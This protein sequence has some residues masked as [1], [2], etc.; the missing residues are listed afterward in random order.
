MYRVSHEWVIRIL[1]GVVYE[2]LKL[3]GAKGRC[4]LFSSTF[5]AIVLRSFCKRL[6]AI[7][8]TRKYFIL[9][10]ELS[11]FSYY[12]CITT[13]TIVFETN[14]R[15]IESILRPIMNIDMSYSETQIQHRNKLS[16]KRRYYF[17]SHNGLKA[18]AH[19]RFL[20]A[21]APALI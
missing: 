15:D 12:I 14:I 20:N 11:L 7:V 10:H 19:N 16:V 6:Q 13:Y 8:G 9:G 5:F 4:R 21:L 17:H 18:L 1:I 3:R 2:M